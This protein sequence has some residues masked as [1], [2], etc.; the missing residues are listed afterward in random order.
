MAYKEL[1]FKT[2]AREKILKGVNALADAVRITLGPK[3]K[4]V[5]MQRPWGRPLVCNDGVTIAKAIDLKDPEENLGAQ[6]IREAA[7]RTG[8]SVG[9]GTSTATVLAQ[10]I[11][12]E[13]LHNIAA[14]ASAID[15]KSGLDRGLKIVVEEIKKLSHPIVSS[16]ERAQ[17][18]TLSA[19]NDPAIGD[20]V[21][22]A[23]EK[24]G[25]EGIVTVE[26]AKGTE[27]LL[28]V[29]EGLQL[30]RGYMS[31]Y[32]VTDSEKMLV[33]LQ[34]PYILLS[35]KRISTMKDLVPLL[36]DVSKTAS[37]LLIISDEVDSEALATLVVNK[38]RGVL[39]CAAVKAPGFGEQRKAL[40][41]D[42]AVVT[43]GILVTEEAGLSLEHISLKD[44]GRA[45]RVLIERDSTTIVGGKGKK[46]NIEGRKEELRRQIEKTKS[47]YDRQKMETRLGKLSGG[48]AVIHVGAPSETELKNKKEAL[49][50]AISATKAAAT[51]GIV[52]GGGLSLL[53]AARALDAEI[54]KCEGDERTGL[55]IL[56]KALEAPT[57]Q[58]AVNSGVDGGVV[59]EKMMSHKGSFGFDAAKN[60]YVD[61]VQ[62]GIVDPTKVVRVALE[63]AVSIAGILLL[64][65]AT[66]TEVPLP[67]ESPGEAKEI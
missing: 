55:A 57:R 40:L 53:R 11:Y 44:L 61:L 15:L 2:E 50:D 26:E 39:R 22:K 32:F 34:D 9:D 7:E 58:I 48:V 67:N 59:I 31:P 63:N 45:S 29:V 36:E 24:V 3:S 33:D 18:A 66:M 4:C 41:E 42:L 23:M 62:A 19:H 30:D 5:L 12:T 60:E 52:P 37:S 35:E 27:T 64:T 46:E 28:E 56:R 14:G 20:L 47:E 21:A 10:A 38:V 54:K 51:E 6:I 13:G 8:E 49:E 25:R 1:H 65:E 17:V 43:G 16:A